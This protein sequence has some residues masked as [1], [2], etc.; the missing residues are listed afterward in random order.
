MLKAINTKVLLAILA[1]LV[2]I[3]GLVARQTKINERN[4]IAAE[5]AAAI[6]KQQQADAQAIKDHDAK[7][8]KEVEEK[9]KKQAPTV[10]KGTWTSYVP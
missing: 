2:T 3:G 6:L 9:K 4:A 8:W 1:A 5:K 7:F 10:N